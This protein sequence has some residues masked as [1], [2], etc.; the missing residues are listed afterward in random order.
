MAVDDR[1]LQP[2]LPPS[3][4]HIVSF[5]FT[6]VLSLRRHRR[7]Q[8]RHTTL[9][10]PLLS[11]HA[12]AGHMASRTTTAKRRRTNGTIAQDPDETATTASTNGM[13]P[14]AQ[15]STSGPVPST[16]ASQPRTA[17]SSTAHLPATSTDHNNLMGSTSTASGLRRSARNLRSINEVV[18]GKVSLHKIV[19]CRFRSG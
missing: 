12:P 1:P 2:R 4:P 10:Q 16:T 19:Q 7:C 14:Y 18:G 13:T 15:S 6:C 3:L 8:T 11:Q 5:R 17:T 9:A